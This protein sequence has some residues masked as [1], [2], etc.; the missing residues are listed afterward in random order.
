MYGT[1]GNTELIKLDRSGNI[2]WNRTFP[3]AGDSS[4]MVQTRDGGFALAGRADTSTTL[5]SL[6]NI[7]FIKTDSTGEMQ[8]NTTFQEKL[9]GSVGGL[10]QV[11]QTSDGNYAIVGYTY[12]ENASVN[13][14]W[15]ATLMMLKI[16]SSG[17]LLWKETYDS[18]ISH[19]GDNSIV[20]TSDGGYVLTDNTGA[21][22][23]TPTAIKID[24]NGVVQWTKTYNNTS[25]KNHVISTIGSLNSVILTSD[26]GLAFAGD[27]NFSQTWVLKTDVSGNVQWN[28]T[29]GDRDQYGYRGICLIESSDGSILLGATGI[30]EAE[31]YITI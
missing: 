17:N 21:S 15:S 22:A 9:G 14:D 10:S 16:S 7:L 13:S 26:G 28:Q 19:W 5:G 8:W 23:G 25:E 12:S 24:E 27:S 3:Y 11:I 4:S 1:Q 6:A 29:Y 18:R 31:I 2:Q 30:I 20:Q